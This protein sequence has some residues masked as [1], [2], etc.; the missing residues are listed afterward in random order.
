MFI[1]EY[2]QDWNKSVCFLIRCQFKSFL[3]IKLNISSVTHL[4][5][6]LIHL[7]KSSITSGEKVCSMVEYSAGLPVLHS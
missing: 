4:V 1:I 6:A 5:L 2:A 7:V 3:L